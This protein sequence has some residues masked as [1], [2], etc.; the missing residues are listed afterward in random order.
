V[1]EWLAIAIGLAG[2]AY[3]SL[4]AAKRVLPPLISRARKPE[5]AIK[6]GFGGAAVAALPAVLLSIVVGATL[7]LP[8]GL[9]G[10]AAAVALVF[11][12]VLLAGVFA[13]ALV[14]RY[15]P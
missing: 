8:W 4:S 7:G 2:G 10:M 11:A 12:G 13:G 5:R 14:A 15:L 9:P 1:T 3:L 6:L